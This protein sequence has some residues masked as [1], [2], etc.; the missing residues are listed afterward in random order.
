MRRRAQRRRAV[1]NN[2]MASSYRLS[3]W[4]I[5]IAATSLIVLGALGW[6]LSIPQQ[7]AKD[8]SPSWSPDGS[9]IA[10][11]SERDGNAE[12]YVMNADGSDQTR[13]TNTRSDEGY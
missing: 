3:R 13:L 7:P 6:W 5:V 4:K 9:K 2:T 11:Y 10:F 1:S 8:G 12:I